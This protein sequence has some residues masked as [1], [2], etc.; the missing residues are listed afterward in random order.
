MLEILKL[1][2][3]SPI[4]SGRL[5]GCRYSRVLDL[6]FLILPI[7]AALT[8]IVAAGIGVVLTGHSRA[9]RLLIPVS[10]G[11]LVLV[12][13]FGLIP[14][15][16]QE[17]GWIR[18]LPLVALGCGSLMAVDRFAFPICPSCDHHRTPQLVAAPLLSAT[19]VHAF[20]DGWGLIALQ[21]AA[22]R[23][24]KAVAAA[25]L[26]HKIPEGLALGTITGVMLGR[27]DTALACC[28]AVE[29][30]TVVGGVVGL[31]L[32]PAGWV[33]YPLAIAAGTFLFLGIQAIRLSTD[34]P[35]GHPTP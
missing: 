23:T 8:A 9:S 31:W 10:G 15:L 22:P 5:N 30:C 34:Q 12:A 21:I 19:A 2:A 18:A 11:F 25:I 13:V 24:G 35:S 7:A 33:S 6:H 20:A 3:E 16:V 4:H 17:I 14:E 32:T 26:L 1:P 27:A 28:A 29:L